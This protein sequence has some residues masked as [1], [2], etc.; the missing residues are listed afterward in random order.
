MENSIVFI[1]QN[2]GDYESFEGSYLDKFIS[3]LIK[4]YDLKENVK[5]FSRDKLSLETFGDNIFFVIEEEMLATLSDVEKGRI[6]VKSIILCEAISKLDLSEYNCVNKYQ[7]ARKICE[8]ILNFILEKSEGEIIKV[9]SDRAEVFAFYSPVGLSGNSTLAETFSYIKSSENKNILHIS[10]DS[11]HEIRF[12]GDSV[13]SASD[14]FSEDGKYSLIRLEKLLTKYNNICYLKNFDYDLDKSCLDEKSFADFIDYVADNGGYDYICIDL[15][16]GQFS[17][18]NSLI[19]S[20]DF[21]VMPLG[22]FAFERKYLKFNEEI[23]KIYDG[24]YDDKIIRVS[25]T[26]RGEGSELECDFKLPYEPY[27]RNKERLDDDFLSTR[28]ANNFRR[29]INER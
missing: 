22:D 12:D 28:F 16:S 14:Y 5:I 26:L 27:L 21:W 20:S 18:L 17:Y 7:N 9:L 25:N 8:Y 23:L 15:N 2:L 19:D 13:Y 10:L 29:A 1:T 24:K 4:N 11:F 3:F 6:S